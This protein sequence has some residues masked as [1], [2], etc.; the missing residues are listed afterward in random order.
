VTAEAKKNLIQHYINENTGKDIGLF[1]VQ[2][3]KQASLES[4]NKNRCYKIT[5]SGL[6]PGLL[7]FSD[8]PSRVVGRMNEAQFMSI[9]RAA[10][11]SPNVAMQGYKT[12]ANVGKPMTVVF[13]ASKPEYDEVRHVITY[14]ACLNGSSKSTPLSVNKFYNVNLYLDPLCYLCGG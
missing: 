1:F 12:P 8:S 3:A 6:Q 2:R 4:L 7:F 5:L 14:Q 10:H 9:W 11:T 13:R